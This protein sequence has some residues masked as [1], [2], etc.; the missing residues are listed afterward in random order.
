M[1]KNDFVKMVNVN[2]GT[3]NN[4][5]IT[6]VKSDYNNLI[7]S[8]PDLNVEK[9]DRNNYIIYVNNKTS[10][11]IEITKPEKTIS[12]G[13]GFKSKNSSYHIEYKYTDDKKILKNDEFT[14]RNDLVLWLKSLNKKTIE[15]LHIY[16][17]LGNICRKSAWIDRIQK[18]G[19]N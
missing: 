5:T 16:D 3:I 11:F 19:T 9:I 6:M 2:N 8:L 17:D 15:Y 12:G 18:T 1:K 13:H 10:Y 14:T 7:E 4:D